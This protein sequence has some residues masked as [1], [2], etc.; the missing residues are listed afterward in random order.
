[1]RHLFYTFRRGHIARGARE[2]GQLLTCREDQRW[3]LGLATLGY[4]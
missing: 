1:M 2:F 4:L 3:M